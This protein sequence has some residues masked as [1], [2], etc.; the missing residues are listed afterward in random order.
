MT[1]RG[2]NPSRSHRHR[3]AWPALRS[4]DR[5]IPSRDGTAPLE[6]VMALPL[7]LMLT[8]TIFLVY[9]AF[10]QELSMIEEARYRAFQS[11]PDTQPSRVL[12]RYAPA[13]DGLSEKVATKHIE[14]RGNIPFDMDVG[15]INSA[16]A[17]TWD[18][19]TVPFPAE[20]QPFVVHEPVARLIGEDVGR[21]GEW[22]QL[23]AAF[24]A[25]MNFPE[26]PAV[27]PLAETAIVLQPV[28]DV[29]VLFLHA[30]SGPVRSVPPVIR[31]WLSIAV[32]PGDNDL[33]DL[34][35]HG[36]DLIA[37]GVEGMDRVSR[38]NQGRKID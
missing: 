12:Q 38:A 24:A 1:R 4:P 29:Q 17:G 21:A 14:W 3:A 23:L 31:A 32:R 7:L 8:F 27:E 5:P 26:H 16:L 20:R 15:S 6:F 2:T 28:V 13:D 33:I 18:Q 19:V 11:L 36:L 35:H 30:A 34:A 37:A 22:Q 9:G 25:N 10:F